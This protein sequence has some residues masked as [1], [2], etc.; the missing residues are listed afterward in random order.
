MTEKDRFLGEASFGKEGS[1]VGSNPA[2]APCL[3]AC[4]EE[5]RP[6]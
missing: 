6:S 1:F 4:K 5:M 2:P 3:K